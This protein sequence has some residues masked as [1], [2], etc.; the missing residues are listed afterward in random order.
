[1]CGIAGIHRLTDHPV[2]QIDRLA[3]NLLAG[4][5]HRGTDATGYAAMSDDG[6]IAVQRASCK[7]SDFNLHRRVIAP[8]ARTVLLHTRFATQGPAAFPENN[9][10]V[11]SGPIYVVHNGHIWND[12]EI[13]WAAPFKRRGQVD[14]EAIAA[15]LRQHDWTEAIPKLGDDLDGDAAFAA[16]NKDEPGELLLV[17]GSTSPLYVLQSKKAIIWASTFDAIRDAW[18]ATY[19][20]G[21][22]LPRID[23]KPEGYALVAR[24]GVVEEARFEP[25]W[26]PYIG[27]SKVQPDLGRIVT[28]AKKKATGGTWTRREG[29]T[30]G[31]MIYS[32]MTP[33]NGDNGDETLA[34]VYEVEDAVRCDD[35]GEWFPALAMSVV[36]VLGGVQQPSLRRLQDVGE[37]RRTHGMT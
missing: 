26:S 23:F 14:S 17:R 33:D 2:S 25:G 28:A 8:D 1:M 30:D 10:P 11:R 13:F 20:R 5:Q 36:K 32:G 27:Q 24:K 9:H 16:I 12:K 31:G 35:C 21:A 4:I 7:A 3:S 15:Y 6:L 18:R 22:T 19:G 37:R 34:R 29:S